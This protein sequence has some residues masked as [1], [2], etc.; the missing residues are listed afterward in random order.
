[1][2]KHTKLTLWVAVMLFYTGAVSAGPQL[3]ASAS[4][5]VSGGG[6]AE[7]AVT[8]EGTAAGSEIVPEA[9]TADAQA[10][11]EAD[12]AVAAEPPAMAPEPV[13]APEP[14]AEA[15]PAA[16]A[17]PIAGYDKGFFIQSP[18]GAFKLVIGA[19]LKTRYDFYA[20]DMGPDEDRD[21]DNAFSVPYARL[22]F[23]GHLFDK[24]L[25]FLFNPELA[26]NPRLILG[27]ADYAFITDK[28]HLTFG[29][30]KRPFSRNYLT[31]SG[32][33]AFIDAPLGEFGRG[34]DF[35]LQLSNNYTKVEGL[36]WAV[37][38]FNGT[39]TATVA[40]FNPT[41]VA[42]IGYN[43]GIKGYYPTDFEGGGLRFGVAMSGHID[44]NADEDGNGLAFYGFDYI[45]KV[46]GFSFNGGVYTGWSGLYDADGEV[47]YDGDGVAD[48]DPEPG[49]DLL[50][51]FVQLQYLIAGKY[52]PVFRY[53]VEIP[54]EDDS[55]EHEITVGF[56]M[57][58]FG[59]N[60]KWENNFCTFIFQ[61]PGDPLVDLAF[62]SQLQFLF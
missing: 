17:N 20:H 59:Q 31:S 48:P 24:K 53:G 22:Y 41:L 57:Y 42:R 43:N 37:G 6:S 32:K 33:R 15:A 12:A 50:G 35:G 11:A 40:D 13:A 19:R 54:Q 60:F 61:T 58:F 55:S 16:G 46:Q 47:D 2:G 18:D 8:T 44:F 62:K 45:L 28:L 7:G 49:Y 3:E 52:E 38:I 4:A 56:T 14:A 34:T 10:D 9:E 51:T 26:G 36:E 29:Q 39:G 23:S 5:E 25:T 27:Y 21:F 1:M 30:F